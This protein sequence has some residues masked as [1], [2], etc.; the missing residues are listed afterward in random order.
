MKKNI[1]IAVLAIVSAASVE[2]TVFFHNQANKLD[3]QKK[4]LAK[5]L[6]AVRYENDSLRST[7]ANYQEV[8]DSIDNPHHH[9]YLLTLQSYQALQK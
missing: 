7:I 9:R 4:V 5:S 8:V 6:S 2:S 1:I 3:Y